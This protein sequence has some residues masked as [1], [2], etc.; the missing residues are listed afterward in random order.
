MCGSD[1]KIQFALPVVLAMFGS[2]ELSEVVSTLIL[3]LPDAD[4]AKELFGALAQDS[5]RLKQVVS[6][7]HVFRWNGLLITRQIDEV[8][9]AYEGEGVRDWGIWHGLVPADSGLLDLLQKSSLRY[10]EV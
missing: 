1:A 10:Y 8:D 4:G 2:E 6:G 3:S 9:C 5:Q 7:K